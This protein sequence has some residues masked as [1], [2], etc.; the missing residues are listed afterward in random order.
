MP[1]PRAKISAV[2]KPKLAKA[3]SWMWLQGLEGIGGQWCEGEIIN[4]PGWKTIKYKETAHD[5]I[6]LA[7]VTTEIEEHG[8]SLPS[9]EFGA[10]GF[11]DP[12]YVSDL[13]IRRKRSRIYFRQQ[14]KRCKQCGKTLQQPLVGVVGNRHPLTSRL[15]EYI[16]QE[17]FSIFRTF[18]DIA[19]ETGVHELIVRNLFTTRAE[20]LDK[21]KMVETPKWIAIDEVYPK[22]KNEPRCVISAPEFRRVL[23]LLVDNKV[24]TIAKWMLQ[25][26]G[27]FSVEV[28]S[29]DMWKAYRKVVQQLFPNAVIVTDR[30]HVHNLLSV[31]L[32]RV[33][34]VVR[35]NMSYTECRKHMRREELL[36][37]N[38]HRLSKKRSKDKK[39]KVR[40]SEKEIVEQWLKNVPD[41]AAAYCLN[42]D[43]SDILQLTDRQKAEEATDLW[44]ERVCKFVED[45]RAKYR[46][47]YKGAEWKDPYGNVP[48]TITDWRT[49]IL[50]YIDYKGYFD[51]NATNGFAEFANKVIKK[52]QKL[53]N[54]TLPVL[55]HKVVHGGVL[56]NRRPPHPLDQ[57][58]SRKRR[59]RSVDDNN[60]ARR[61]KNPNANVARLERAQRERYEIEDLLP[62]PQENLEWTTRFET[63]VQFKQDHD[64]NEDELDIKA[65]DSQTKNEGN[66]SQPGTGHRSRRSPKFNK[67]QGNLF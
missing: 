55:R 45:F 59:T 52:A 66:Q 57:K 26:P 25:F 10:W 43:F 49:S 56:V 17:S 27:R 18:S 60:G 58:R 36:L 51:I 9:P 7:E 15:V 2:K 32:K 19:D 50:N 28:V 8:C 4:L 6:I 65:I 29:M 1:L 34:E 13:P 54:Y 47:K 53:G 23:D 39:G 38:Y 33:V 64:T 31:A 30:Y 62:K 20:Q 11:T 46:K 63:I 21:I 35:D 67:N 40:P 44:L 41:I 22:K 5:I 12:S 48:N 3:A 16:E 14:R 61:E 37:K 24:P 42:S